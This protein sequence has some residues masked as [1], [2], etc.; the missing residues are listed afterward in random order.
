ALYVIVRAPPLGGE[1]GGG[2][3]LTVAA[4]DLGVA[5]SVRD[6]LGVGHLLAELGEAGLYLLDEVVDHTR[7]SKALPRAPRGSAPP[8]A[9]RGRSLPQRAPWAPAR[10]NG[11]PPVRWPR[12]R[13]R[14]RAGPRAAPRA[15]RAR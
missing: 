15:P 14:P 10:F 3:E 8:R 13:R 1:R 12:P 2:L 5:L 11:R 7:Q 9:R 4:P 6:H